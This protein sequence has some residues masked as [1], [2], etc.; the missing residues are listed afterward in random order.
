MRRRDFVKAMVAVPVAAQTTFGQQTETKPAIPRPAKTSPIE[1]A[2][3]YK[4]QPITASVADAVSATQAHFFTDQ[5]MATL[6]KLCVTLMPAL[7][8]YPGATEVSAPEFIDFLIG[9]SPAERQQMYRAGLNRLNVDA[10][11]QFSVPFGRVNEAQADKLL[12]PWLRTW[13]ANH[14]PTEPFADFVNLVH[15]DIRT[16]TMN[17]QAWSDAATSA[18]ERAPGVDLYWSPIDPDI[19]KCV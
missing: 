16:A 11:K 19:Q 12:R 14:P 3:N 7:N 8:G 4:T 2:P 18:G 15:Q 10:Q 9:A 6:R 1:A 13:M 17:S 5:Q